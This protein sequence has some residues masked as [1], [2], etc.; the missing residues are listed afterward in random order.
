[1]RFQSERGGVDDILR[2]RAW[3]PTA[4]RGREAAEPTDRSRIAA[5]AL[6]GNSPHGSDVVIIP[7]LTVASYCTLT[8][9]IKVVPLELAGL[10]RFH[11]IGRAQ[12]GRSTR[13][14]PRGGAGLATRVGT[15]LRDL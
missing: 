2:R 12:P 10:P 11:A 13:A 9:L 3:L 6:R 4:S 1:M 5:R 8:P 15:L 14:C 7:S